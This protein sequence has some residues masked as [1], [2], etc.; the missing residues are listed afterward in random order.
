M[1]RKNPNFKPQKIHWSINPVS[2]HV[3]M[4]NDDGH[5]VFTF[6]PGHYLGD[7]TKGSSVIT[8]SQK[9]NSLVY[10]SGLPWDMAKAYTEYYGVTPKNVLKQ[11]RG[12]HH[13]ILARHPEWF[14]LTR[15]GKNGLPDMI[16]TIVNVDL[17]DQAV[18]DGIRNVAPIINL[19][20]K[21]PQELKVLLGKSL[22]KSLCKNSYTR[23]QYLMRHI[24]NFYADAGRIEVLK[25]YNKLPSSVLAKR[26]LLSFNYVHL[27]K[28]KEVT[29]YSW[30][31]LAK[32]MGSD[33]F[34][35]LHIIRDTESMAKQYG[36]PF[37]MKWSYDK[38][39]AL[40]E[41][42]TK[43]LKERQAEMERQRETH[44]QELRKVRASSL[45]KNCI[46]DEILGV[47]VTLLET[48]QDVQD[49][50]DKMHHCV[51]AYAYT[52]AEGNYL[53]YHL[54][55]DG[56]GA[57]LGIEVTKKYTT[58]ELIYMFSQCYGVC[59]EILQDTAFNDAAVE[60][61]KQLNEGVMS[62]KAL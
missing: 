33:W 17:I 23:N 34:S 48:A 31:K 25:E 51:G 22:W 21:N 8:S 20:G 55:K 53:V 24:Y 37:N 5:I 57:T 4:F 7:A 49:E 41:K 52:V 29:G 18:K 14:K 19:F 26:H 56:V 50:G 3:E 1:A 38:I 13:K 46:F 58:G 10:P 28:V 44:Y 6:R 47:K 2:E 45:H 30:K 62:E 32:P 54:E 43:T 27:A 40:H 15:K 16:G 35:H 36:E 39:K 60:I 42:L 9:F 61:I 11:A 12:I 59:N